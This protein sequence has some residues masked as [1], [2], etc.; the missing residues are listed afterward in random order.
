MKKSV[1]I[2][3]SYLVTVLSA[4][5]PHLGSAPSEESWNNSFYLQAEIEPT[6]ALLPGLWN[7]DMVISVYDADE[8]QK[9]GEGKLYQ[10]EGKQKAT[11]EL[12]T[13]REEGTGVRLLSVKET[14]VLTPELPSTQNQTLTGDFPC[15]EHAFV[16][17]G[18]ENLT[19][20]GL[21]TVSLHFPLTY[22]RINFKV[23]G[24]SEYIG[25]KINDLCFSSS[26]TPV[27]G[28]FSLDYETGEVEIKASDDCSVTV[29]CKEP[30]RVAEG[31]NYVWMSLLPCSLEQETC[32]L[33]FN[34]TDR[35]GNPESSSVT[36]KAR[37]LGQGK[38]NTLTVIAMDQLVTSADRTVPEFTSTDVRY[39]KTMSTAGWSSAKSIT[40]DGMNWM[41]KYNG[42]S[43]DRW[44]GYDGV[45]PDEITSTNS[46]GFWRTGKYKG[47]NV[48]VNP[49]GNVTII[50]GI[51]GL[52]PDF[53]R[54]QSQQE[55]LVEYN[56]KF[57]DVSQWA[58]WANRLMYDFGFNF[59]SCGPQRGRQY[60]Y[61]ITSEV[62]QTLESNIPGMEAS[63]VTCIAFLRT[64]SWDYYSLTK[65]SPAPTDKASVF[66]LMFDPEFENYVDE[67]A[68]DITAYYIGN[69]NFIGYY[70]DNELQF[71]WADSK[72]GIGLK[73]WLALEE[74]ANNPRCF[75]YARKYSEDFIRNNYNVEPV[76]ANVTDEMEEA[77][78]LDV[79]RYYYRTVTSAVRKYDPDH[80]L[81]GS[82]L[83]GA[84]QWQPSV[85]KACA[86]YN[87]VVSTN[88]YHV[89]EPADDYYVDFIRKHIGDKP[90]MITEFYT[91]NEKE[92]FKGTPYVNSGEGGG[93]IV[94]SQEDRGRYYENFTRKALSLTNIVGWQYFQA[95]DDYLIN[96]GWNNKGVATPDFQYY[97]CYPRMR[98]LHWNIYQILDYYCGG[99][100]SGS[101]NKIE[102]VIWE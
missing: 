100:A 8:G 34:F 73:W 38:V 31:D 6:D 99:T 12:W 90:C 17:S 97:G 85:T 28:P 78:L 47:H 4:C 87:D 22:L 57:A 75:P 24:D 70:T 56:A 79:S 55:S 67:L 65:V 13:D 3:L 51:N 82:R 64:F 18:V 30:I 39:K 88:I 81:L 74:S 32:T 35:K 68:K 71:R 95:M 29:A 91:R 94:T 101:E 9:C 84:P 61:T 7:E 52:N 44:G 54:P 43:H 21:N 63:H 50:H 19:K 62:E 11:F 1:T 102:N 69:P 25:Y 14:D 77:F 36:F 42:K 27:C 83:H 92:T 10:G 58:V 72:P 45:K 16:Y 20:K 98:R 96:Y 89:W 41:D 26:K 46:A 5:T 76:A 59:F 2:V 66:T 40:V 37:N 48:M 15:W 33:T 60:R 80:L 23:N 53:L 93:W 86:E 49:D